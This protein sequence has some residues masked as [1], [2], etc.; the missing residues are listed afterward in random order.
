MG[1]MSDIAAVSL[2]AASSL[3]L[4]AETLVYEPTR[5][6]NLAEVTTKPD[7]ATQWRQRR[8][9]VT[10]APIFEP[11]TASLVP[12][13]VDKQNTIAAPIDDARTVIIVGG[14]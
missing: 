4:D 3:A 9:S 13:N 8:G 5:T 2:P 6:E 1:G 10:P 11:G 14:K 12:K 7:V